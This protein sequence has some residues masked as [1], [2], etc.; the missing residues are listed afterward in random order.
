MGESYYSCYLYLEIRIMKYTTIIVISKTTV[1]GYF[2]YFEYIAIVS[3]NAIYT[4]TKK[5]IMATI[6][7]NIVISAFMRF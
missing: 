4:T 3:L 5:P 7:L 6:V 2:V 1:K